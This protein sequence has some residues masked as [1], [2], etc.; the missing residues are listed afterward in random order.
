MEMKDLVTLYD[1]EKKSY[2]MMP[3]HLSDFVRAGAQDEITLRRNRSAL[4]KI[5]LNPRIFRDV[6]DRDLSTSVLGKKISFPV[7]MTAAGGQLHMHEEGELASAR[8]CNNFGTVYGTPM[9]SG[10]SLEKIAEHTPGRKWLQIGQ[11]SNRIQEHFIKRAEAAGY[12]AIVLTA[13]TPVPS[14]RETEIRNNFSVQSTLSWGSVQ[15][16]E[17]ELLSDIPLKEYIYGPSD[18]SKSENQFSAGTGQ[19]VFEGITW[20]NASWIRDL[21]DL[22]IIIKGVRNVEDA[23]LCAQAGFNGITISNHGGRHLDGTKSAIEVLAEIAPAVEDQI[24][25]YFDSGIRRGMDVLKAIA[26]GAN[27]VLIGR[28]IFWGLTVSGEKGLNRILEILRTEVDLGMAYLGARSV[29]EIDNSA[30]TTE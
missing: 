6:S 11:H 18:E 3:S 5:I 20:E 17:E 10:Y 12:E 29:Q 24:E 25:V 27:A 1:F 13:D 14:R 7:M 30:I 15:G 16:Y 9:N 22:P 28:P 19:P 23:R 2:E 8:A 26:L 4:D 21:T